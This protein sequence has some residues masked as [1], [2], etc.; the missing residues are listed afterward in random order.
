LYTGWIRLVTSTPKRQSD[1]DFEPDF[2][3][4]F[5][6]DGMG[7]TRHRRPKETSNLTFCDRHGPTGA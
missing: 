4:D 7:W 3:F 1:F 2:D 6:W 5:E